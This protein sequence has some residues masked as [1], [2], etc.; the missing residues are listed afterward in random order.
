MWPLRAT[1]EAEYQAEVSEA[2]GRRAVE[3]RQGAVEAR[4]GASSRSAGEA[5]SSSKKASTPKRPSAPPASAGRSRRHTP[6]P[7]EFRT[8]SSKKMPRFAGVPSFL[9]LPVPSD[10]EVVPDV[11]VVL[12]GAPFD[13]GASFRPGARFGPRAVREASALARRFSAA[14]GIDIFEELMVADGGDV[15]ASP[16]DADAALD[17]VSARAEAISRTGA[18]CG[19]VGGDQSVTLAALRGIHRAKLKSVGLIHIDS[20]SN[21][22]GPAWG[23]NVHHGSAV[24]VAVEEGLVR[25]EEVLQIGVR[26]PYS[27]PADLDYA[28]AHGFEVAKMDDVKWDLYSVIGQVRKAVRGGSIYVSVDVSALDPAYAPGT[29]IPSPGGM[30][31]WELQQLLRALVG[32]DLVGFD[33][34]EIAP[35]YDPAGITA[36]AG[37]TVLQEILSSLADTRRSA[38]PAP[39]TRRSESRRGKRVSP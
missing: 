8:V 19:F 7:P 23:R 30:N 9:R 10:P 33:L 3:A 26:G 34:V 5:A 2:R 31:T 17:A 32:A 16:H 37:V 36:M 6:P 35:A 28:L 29:G 20:H 12:C 18:T 22:S 4:Q 39:S 14:L 15:A 24:R 21:T 27:G 25:P 38:R 1:H 13:S 11:D